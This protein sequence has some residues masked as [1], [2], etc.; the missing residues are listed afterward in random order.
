MPCGQGVKSN[1]KRAYSQAEFNT[2]LELFR[3]ENNW[4]HQYKYPMMA[5]WA[6]HLIHW[7]DDTC[8]FHVESPHG[9]L[10][11]PFAIQT[12]TKW[13]KNVETELQCPDQMLFG[14]EDWRTCVQLHLLLY[15]EGWLQ[16]H[17]NALHM[18]TEND[19][20]ELGPKNLN[21][22]YGNRV[23]AVCWN[24]P[25]FK[26][27]E[28]Q[29][30]PDQKG[31]GTHSNRKY[32]STRANRR[33]ATKGQVQFRGR[34]TTEMNSSIVTKHY[35]SPDDYYTNAFVASTL[36]E[37]GP[38]K[39]MLRDHNGNGQVHDHWLFATVIPNI[40]RRFERDDR[41]CCVMALAK[42]WAVFDES[43]LED[44]P[45]AK[46]ERI[47]HSFVM[48]F[49]KQD[50]NP[51]VKVLLEVLNVDGRLEV[52]PVANNDVIAN[53]TNNNADNDKNDGN[54]RDNNKQEPQQQQPRQR[55]QQQQ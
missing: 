15:L 44:I 23:K 6:Y 18:F 24:N 26:A 52:V 22:Q 36:C 53:N 51:V 11:Y 40:R 29:T 34:W 14:S 27:L 30:R 9:C 50:A 48:N 41:F 12:K 33:G 32:A 10:L 5:L 20:E 55:Q 54:C 31:L 1:D 46:T 37:G 35:I 49:G 43:A 21:K 4:D 3:V 45:L 39:Y 28:D 2:A 25:E 16:R 13:S 7:L 38:A 47:K 19:D 42:L 8:H 17:P